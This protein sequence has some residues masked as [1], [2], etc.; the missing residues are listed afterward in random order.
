MLRLFRWKKKVSCDVAAEQAIAYCELEA[1]RIEATFSTALAPYCDGAA[2]RPLLSQIL[3]RPLVSFKD[4]RIQ[5]NIRTLFAAHCFAIV[6]A[7]ELESACEHLSP[8]SAARSIDWRVAML[9]TE[10]EV[11]PDHAGHAP[12]P[13]P[14]GGGH[15]SYAPD[16]LVGGTPSQQ[17]ALVRRYRHL[18]TPTEV[19]S[20]FCL[21]FR[22]VLPTAGIGMQVLKEIPGSRD[23]GVASFEVVG[24]R[25]AVPDEVDEWS[26]SLKI[27]DTDQ[28]LAPLPS[29]LRNTLLAAIDDVRPFWQSFCKRHKFT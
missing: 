18:Q 22:I 16:T 26:D 12:N 21:A 19:L 20:M 13:Y 29:A 24:Y 17:L 6:L 5:A 2:S 3:A 28:V 8:V 14:E 1:K 4:G 25:R 11:G 23:G 10:Q 27:L 7:K 9:I 15:I